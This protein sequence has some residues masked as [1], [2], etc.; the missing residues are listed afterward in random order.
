M[1]VCHFTSRIVISSLYSWKFSRGHSP[2]VVPRDRKREHELPGVSTLSNSGML[3]TRPIWLPF[4]ASLADDLTA[5]PLG[6][7]GRSSGADCRQPASDEHCN[8][9]WQL[10]WVPEARPGQWYKQG[11]ETGHAAPFTWLSSRPPRIFPLPTVGHRHL[12][13]TDSPHKK[14]PKPDCLFLMM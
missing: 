13:Q 1:G 12:H 7:A 8:L 9:H 4:T 2:W 11:T 5:C 10:P 14:Q 3:A 6:Q